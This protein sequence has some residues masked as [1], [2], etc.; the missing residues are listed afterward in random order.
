METLKASLIQK[1]NV[2]A[3]RYTSYPAVP[4]WDKEA[5]SAGQWMEVV[6]RTFTESNA[7]KGMSMYIHLPFC[8]ALCTYCGC[9]TRIIKNY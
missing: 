4:F 3:P 7:T 2:P 5:P 8:E 9:N 6:N 1:Y